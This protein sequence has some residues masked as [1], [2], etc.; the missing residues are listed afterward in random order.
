MTNGPTT[1]RTELARRSSAGIDVTLVW[2][3]ADGADSVLVCVCDWA[4]GAYFEIEAE[5]RLA[6][7]VYHHPFAY[8]DLSTVDYQDSRLAA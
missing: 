7:D 4:H 6:L 5:P 8:R 1:P 2:V 3:N